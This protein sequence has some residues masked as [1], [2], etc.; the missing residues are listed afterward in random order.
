MKQ[1]LLIFII[2]ILFLPA[3]AQVGNV[4]INTTNPQAML[5]VKDSSVL[6]TGALSLP[7]MPGN[8]PVSGAGA[9]MMWYADK[10]A[11]RTGKSILTE[12]DKDSVGDYSF[13]AGINVKAKG[14]TA[15][16]LGNSNN[17]INNSDMATGSFTTASGGSSASFGNG[18]LA[19]GN[20]SVAFGNNTIASGTSA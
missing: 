12:W 14:Y 13:A 5:H 15:I 8:P 2:A 20:S 17:A 7:V 18:T 16:A 3:K 19:A 10:A 6:F 9:R 11:L 1:L 4:G